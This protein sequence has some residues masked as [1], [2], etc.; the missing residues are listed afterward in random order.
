MYQ[1]YAL[2]VTSD[3]LKLK[4]CNLL[5]RKNEGETIRNNKNVPQASQ[6][7]SH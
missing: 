2:K 6:I 3:H 7:S 4:H 1:G 5:R